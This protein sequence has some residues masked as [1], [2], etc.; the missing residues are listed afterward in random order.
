MNSKAVEGAEGHVAIVGCAFEEW[1]QKT[2]AMLL[3][4][5]QT[6]CEGV[7]VFHMLKIKSKATLNSTLRKEMYK[8]KD[9]SIKFKVHPA[10]EELCNRASKLL[11]LG[12][13][14]DDADSSA[15]ADEGN[16]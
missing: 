11:A 12:A 1:Q 5:K 14:C 15:I 16:S 8:H 3:Q 2:D 9:D 6:L 10:I 7:F 13:T 4:G